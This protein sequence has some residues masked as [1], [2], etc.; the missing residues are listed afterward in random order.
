MEWWDGYLVYFLF[1]SDIFFSME[2]KLLED[3]RASYALSHSHYLSLTLL[4][5]HWLNIVLRSLASIGELNGS[6]AHTLRLVCP[7]LSFPL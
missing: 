4:V 5:A 6:L 7:F 2:K 3:L 1:L